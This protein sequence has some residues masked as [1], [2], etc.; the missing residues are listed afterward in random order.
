VDIEVG[1][2]LESCFLPSCAARRNDGYVCV[3]PVAACSVLVSCDDLLGR[4]EAPGCTSE[5]RVSIS[6]QSR[7]QTLKFS[8]GI[9]SWRSWK[10][11][12]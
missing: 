10:L 2:V 9:S 8:R 3:N 5:F 12:S 1:A 6:F 4:Q 7:A 11:G